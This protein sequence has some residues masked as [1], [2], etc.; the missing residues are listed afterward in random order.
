MPRTR[1]ERTNRDGVGTPVIAGGVSV[2]IRVVY[3]DVIDDA[4]WFDS[5]AGSDTTKT[6]CVFAAPTTG[7]S[8]GAAGP[9]GL[10]VDRVTVVRV[11]DSNHIV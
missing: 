5:D 4:S 11:L 7:A 10:P 2:R 6:I 1:I 8:Q 3:R 9:H